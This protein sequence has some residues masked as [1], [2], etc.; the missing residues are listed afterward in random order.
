MPRGADPLAAFMALLTPVA[1]RDFNKAVLGSPANSEK[2]RNNVY[3]D[4]NSCISTHP[5]RPS[6][7]Q[8]REYRLAVKELRERKAT[9]VAAQLQLIEDGCDLHMKI[10][11][12]HV[13]YEEWK[14]QSNDDVRAQASLYLR[15]SDLAYC[16]QA[17]WCIV[18][19]YRESAKNLG[20]KE[21]KQLEQATKRI[22]HNVAKNACLNVIERV[23]FRRREAAL[24]RIAKALLPWVRARVSE[25]RQKDDRLFAVVVFNRSVA[26]RKAKVVAVRAS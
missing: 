26:I 24:S 8:M 21:A 9:T 18:M 22:S 11:Q 1:K 23:R 6:W 17:V 2:P 25:R 3:V 19:K 4:C 12:A 16:S 13:P 14:Q 7:T 15:S 10:I 20:E 5:H